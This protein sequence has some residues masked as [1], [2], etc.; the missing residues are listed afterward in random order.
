MEG[1]L[2]DDLV[3]RGYIQMDRRIRNQVVRRGIFTSTRIVR[4]AGGEL[5]TYNSVYEI[6]VVEPPRTAMLGEQIAELLQKADQADSTP[7]EDG[8]SVP[9]EVARREDRLEKLRQATAQI[10]ARA[11]ERQR[12]ELAAFEEKQKRRE[13]QKGAGKKPK[14]REPQPPKEGPRSKDPYNFTDP[15]SRI[16]KTGSGFAQSYNAQAAVEVESRLLV[17]QAVSDAPN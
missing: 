15:E 8:L 1:F 6:T 9:Q 17:S 12:E 10:Q 5:T 3:E 7:L 13:E 11:R 2:L 16:M 14:G 4:I